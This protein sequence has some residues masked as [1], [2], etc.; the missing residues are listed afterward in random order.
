MILSK[1]EDQTILVLDK[2]IE[3]LGLV[4]GSANFLVGKFWYGIIGTSRTP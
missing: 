3:E 2:V 4:E 1:L